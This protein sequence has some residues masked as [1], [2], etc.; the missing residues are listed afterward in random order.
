MDKID[1]TIRAMCGAHNYSINNMHNLKWSKH[2]SNRTLRVASV[3]HSE[4]KYWDSLI[5]SG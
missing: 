5:V 4:D 2:A 3:Q 1:L